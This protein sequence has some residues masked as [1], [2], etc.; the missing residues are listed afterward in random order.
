[1]KI[2]NDPLKGPGP[3]QKSMDEKLK[4][5]S[6][7]YEKHFLGEMMKAMR[8][9]VKEGGIVQANQAEKI[10]REQ[11]DDIAQFFRHNF[12]ED[13]ATNGCLKNFL[14]VTNFDLRMQMRT[15]KIIRNDRLCR[16]TETHT[17]THHAVGVL[18]EIVW[19]ENHVL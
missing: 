2:P 13:H 10:F 17:F 15:I 18:G 3:Q 12:V 1:M 4:D 11:L 9:T 14:L 5:V 8:S 16:R 7:L 19:S 6:A